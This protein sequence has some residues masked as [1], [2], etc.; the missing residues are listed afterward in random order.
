M[1]SREGNGK[2]G[3]VHDCQTQYILIIVF[4]HTTHAKILYNS[5]DA[6]QGYLAYTNMIIFSTSL[7][8]TRNKNNVGSRQNMCK[9]ACKCC[10]VD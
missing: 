10:V 4:L 8:N 5:T 3:Y 7:T 1:M 9:R 2:I 6:L